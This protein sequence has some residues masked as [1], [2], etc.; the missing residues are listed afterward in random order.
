MVEQDEPVVVLG[1][2]NATGQC[3]WMILA[4]VR[5]MVFGAIVLLQG[6]FTAL[7]AADTGTGATLIESAD[8]A[9]MDNGII[10]AAIKKA[11][12]NL[13]SFRF[14]G[15]ELLSRGGGY[16]SA[17]GSGAEDFP[18]KPGSGV[19]AVVT[20]PAWKAGERGK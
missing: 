15:V 7:L 19:F 1:S 10:Q 11:D 13:L 9:T 4:I 2:P 18:E 16:W 3:E 6:A 20:D 14:H 17:V 8:T 12:G 5:P